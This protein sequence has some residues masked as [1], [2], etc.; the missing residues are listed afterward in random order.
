MFHLFFF[1]VLLGSRRSPL[2]SLTVDL[3][4]RHRGQMP[5]RP[6]PSWRPAR[7]LSLA[8]AGVDHSPRGGRLASFPSRSVSWLLCPCG[9]RRNDTIRPPDGTGRP[10]GTSTRATGPQL[11][12][13]MT[14]SL[15][16]PPSR[17]RHWDA[18]RP[19]DT[20]PGLEPADRRPRRRT[21]APGIWEGRQRGAA[22]GGGW[23]WPRHGSTRGRGVGAT[24]TRPRGAQVRGRGNRGRGKREGRGGEAD[25]AR[26]TRRGW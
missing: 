8:G 24:A 7:L 10:A 18:P 14:P 6:L 22:T 15:P 1:L 13:R 26:P 25:T 11:G 21:A 9:G 5:E 16:I 2:S 12:P 19:F 17:L 23:H 4:S 3:S 20:G